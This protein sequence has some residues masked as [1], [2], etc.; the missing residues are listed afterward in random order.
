MTAFYLAGGIVLCIAAIIVFIAA[1]ANEAVALIGVAVV[2]G[3]LGGFGVA[4]DGGFGVA[5]GW[6]GVNA[7]FAHKHAAI[8]RDV[9]REGFTLRSSDVYVGG[10]SPI[11]YSTSVDLY[12]GSCRV[13]FVVTKINGKWHVTLPAKDGNGVK[14]LTPAD[15]ALLAPACSTK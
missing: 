12:A 5:S 14:I 4:S 3:I 15:V 8:Y 1:L 10:H 2:T 7:T 9:T 6:H 11:F 13:P